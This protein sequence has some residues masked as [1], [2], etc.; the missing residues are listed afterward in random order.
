M[1]NQE[2]SERTFRVK[3]GHSEVTV[4]ANSAAEAI[5]VARRQLAAEM[6]RFYDVISRVAASRFE[7]KSAA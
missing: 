5:A 1:H 6:P 3:L 2:S 4:R 7:V